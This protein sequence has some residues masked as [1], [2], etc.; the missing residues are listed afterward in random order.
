MQGL[1]TGLSWSLVFGPSSG[2][3]LSLSPTDDT[4]T[5]TPTLR[6]C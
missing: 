2:W 5:L 3:W 1:W 4:L 6:A